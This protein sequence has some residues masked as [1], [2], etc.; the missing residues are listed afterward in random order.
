MGMGF[1]KQLLQKIYGIEQVNHPWDGISEED[2]RRNVVLPWFSNSSTK[3]I[4][5]QLE[6]SG[7]KTIQ[8]SLYALERGSHLVAQRLLG[9]YNG[10][11]KVN[12]EPK[13]IRVC[14]VGVH[15]WFPMKI[16]NRVI[17]EPIGTSSYFGAKMHQA[18]A[19][20]LK[21]EGYLPQNTHLDIIP[22]DGEGKILERVEV[23][24]ELLLLQKD[25]V[26]N[27]DLIIF[28]AH[29][30]GSPVSAILIQ[31]LIQMSII[32]PKKQN[33][34]ILAMAGISH[35]P[36]PHLKSSVIIKYVET[37][38]A[39]EL[40]DFNDPTSAVSIKYKG[41]MMEILES[42]VRYVAVGS[43]YDQVVPLY[44]ATVQGINHPNIYR[45]L[46]IH[47]QDYIPDFLSHL[48]VFA[49][50][51]R[52]KG[53]SDFGL[54]VILSDLLAGSIYGF[55]TQG[56]S[57]LYEE[58]DTYNLGINFI[59]DPKRR[60]TKNSSFEGLIAPTKINPYYLP[61]IMARL[62]ESRDIDRNK[63]LKS[64]LETVRELFLGWTPG[65]KDLRDL[66]YRLE[67]LKSKM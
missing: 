53:I 20:Y 27:A 11:F 44:S 65:T 38:H 3:S 10:L 58:D 25:V 17:G 37:D 36:F 6:L 21:G 22:L 34:G 32:D 15:G 49:L 41:A 55:G 56:H 33:T 28:S 35:G 8:Q 54:V 47:A 59:M 4:D 64:D 16:F 30:Q 66:K 57:A 67:P 18:V 61:W 19:T 5:S 23:L 39:K 1:K 13:R 9:L 51:L 62:V 60:S 50:K 45:A 7:S 52:N 14:I 26:M 48:V 46:F 42:G 31:K 12:E 2:I 63:E 40:F 24:L 43:W 29:S